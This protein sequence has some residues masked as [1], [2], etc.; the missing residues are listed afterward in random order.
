MIFKY[1]LKFN[2]EPLNIQAINLLQENKNNK[3]SLN[4]ELCLS[5]EDIQK[6]I[7]NDQRPKF[8][9]LIVNIYANYDKENLMKLIYSKNGNLYS[10]PIFD[11]LS[12]RSLKVGDLPFKDEKEIKVFQKILLNVSESKEEI[13]YLIK[14]SKG[15]TN[16]L[17]FIQDNCKTICSILEEKASYFSYQR[18]NYLLTLNNLSKEDN[19]IEEIFEILAKILNYTKDK[20]YKIIN[21]D[22]IFD[23]MVDFFS[24]K[25]LK[26]FCT[27]HKVIGL[28]KSQKINS[29]SINDYYYKVHQKGMYLIKNNKLTIEEII[30][31]ILSQDIYYFNPAF[32]NDKNRDPIIF[33]YIPITDRD[34]NYLKNVQLIKQS[35]IW[36]LFS[37]SS[38]SKQFHIIILEQ[39]QKVKD[40]RSIFD[41]FPLKYYDKPFAFLINGKINELR[42]TILDEK[43]KD[44]NV[45]FDILDNWFFINDN[46]ELDMN[47]L[48]QTIEIDYNFTSK[49]YFHILKNKKMKDIVM[50]IKNSILF[51]FL[52]QNREGISNAESLI[53][54]LLLSKDDKLC[55]YFLDELDNKILTEKDFYEKEESEN[56][57]LFKL[58][59][60]K[61]GE[62]IKD[63]YISKGK[64]L[65]NSLRIRN[66]ILNDLKNKIIKY[67]V[68]NNLIDE[69]KTF[70]NKI[71]AIEEDKKITDKIYNEIK[72]DFEQ[73]KQIFEEL[74]I[75][76]EYYKTFFSNSKKDTILLIH[77]KIRQFKQKNL[78]ELIEYENF[79]MDNPNF[80]LDEAIKESQ[81]IKYK[82]SYFFMVI[83]NKEKNENY[84]K[85]DEEIFN[86]A[87][88]DYIDTLKRII[89]QKESKEPFFRINNVKEILKVIQNSNNDMKKEII[90]IEKEFENLNK[91]DYIRKNLLN[92]LINFSNKDKVSKLLN[93]IIYF[94]ESYNKINKIQMT[95]FINSFKST[96]N[97]IILDEV[98]GEEIKK[99]ID[100]LK[101]YD[102]DINNETSIIKFYELLLGKEEAI[103]FIKQIK[104][105]NLDI[106]N[107]NE[108]IDESDNSQL[109]TTD[110]DNLMDV[111]RFFIK[112]MENKDIKT[113]ENL[114]IIF[115]E[116][117]DKNKENKDIIIKMQGY[118]NIYGEII[119]LYNS[120]HE[121]P[122]MTTQKV[123][124]ILKDSIVKLYKEP[125]LNLFTFNIKYSSQNNKPIE[126]N[127]LEEL[128]NKLLMSST[129]TNV[130]K[131]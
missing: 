70:Y 107:L 101:K 110:V 52:R 118:L 11:L 35:E 95:E 116:E 100:L 6:L 29:K 68:V 119:Q 113:D 80:D 39:M 1:C 50:Q 27:L 46:L 16:S 125:N 79:F 77:H 78:N 33:K 8:N 92:D 129:N 20:N 91:K 62:L 61:C 67:D 96:Y 55:M 123:D 85:S 69:N 126:I 131:I 53:S 49:Y 25:E 51:F 99:G 36:N 76:E 120:Y 102:Y 40:F 48:V 124:S 13:N 97:T 18:T 15:L 54:L 82:N 130:L 127:E 7:L 47:Y 112:L 104:D 28:L 90:F 24:S 2:L 12:Y 60:K 21:L 74:E 63:R 87:K 71:L 73:C 105:S 111:Y 42:Y 23:N 81:N 72:L 88:T 22:E 103:L 84:H 9:S 19:N 121:N 75:V 114:L 59:L 38:F 108:F 41:I 57:L 93:G 14:I 64:Y 89:N 98:S 109:Q 94:I 45:L 122:E 37:G 4:P 43:E 3:N 31:F 30:N 32:K 17:R 10:R 117:F 86:K 83:Y 26:E 5:N 115:R 58:F 44:F 34:K 106:R 56:F 66:K 128:R 65:Q